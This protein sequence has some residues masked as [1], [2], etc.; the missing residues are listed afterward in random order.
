MTTPVEN[1]G[2]RRVALALFLSL[3]TE[4]SFMFEAIS[5]VEYAAVAKP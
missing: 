3:M 2:F 5:P 4:P 1:Q